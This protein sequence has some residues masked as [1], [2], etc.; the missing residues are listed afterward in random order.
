VIIVTETVITVTENYF[1]KIVRPTFG[2]A[3][4]FFLPAVLAT[5]VIRSEKEDKILGE[6]RYCFKKSGQAPFNFILSKSVRYADGERRQTFFLK[7]L[8]S[9]RMTQVVRTGG[10]F[11]AL[12]KHDK[13]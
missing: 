6:D 12:Q 11:Q 1:S 8:F 7:S 13:T 10:F 5:W 3:S 4:S 9:E 2:M